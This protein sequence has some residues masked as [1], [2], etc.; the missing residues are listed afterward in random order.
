M[1]QT[2][3]GYVATCRSHEDSNGTVTAEWELRVHYIYHPGSPAQLYGDA[4]HPGDDPLVEFDFV[5][6]E[7][8]KDGR[9]VWVRSTDPDMIDWA[10]DWL[11]E[12]VDDAMLDVADEAD[13]AA[14]YRAEC[15][16]DALNADR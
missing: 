8:W 1:T 16:R 14:E 13:R 3:K 2:M 11:A 10:E 6:V 15:R 5:E 4:P 12:H 7:D 9:S